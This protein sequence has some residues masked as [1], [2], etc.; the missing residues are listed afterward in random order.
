MLLQKK[1]VSKE[2]IQQ[3]I[4]KQIYETIYQIFQW[5]EG[6]FEFE[7]GKE[8]KDLKILPSLSLDQLLLNVS[9]MTD[10]W[11]EIEAVIPTMEMVFEKIPKKKDAQGKGDKGNNQ[12]AQEEL[13]TDQRL[14]YEQVNG[15]RTVRE[16]MEQSL[17]GHFETCRILSE[18]L[19]KGLIRIAKVQKGP[20]FTGAEIRRSGT[21][22]LNYGVSVFLI[23][24]GLFF[25]ARYAFSLIN[26]RYI[27]A[28]DLSQLM[29]S[30]IREVVVP[31]LYERYLTYRL[32]HHESP[33][34]LKDFSS[35]GLLSK[36]E[37]AVLTPMLVK[38]Y[39]KRWEQEFPF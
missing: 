32:M 33:F 36:R 22:A 39:E 6:T 15:I 4:Q 24:L 12:E 31:T 3:V 34:S 9:W 17:M 19:K 10:E 30:Q 18:L 35:S 37:A 5:K 21:K 8:P 7:P 23:V 27:Y 14:V 20:I 13:T 1:F 25:S 38:T 26:F 2:D 16:I 28:P 29:E 11:Q